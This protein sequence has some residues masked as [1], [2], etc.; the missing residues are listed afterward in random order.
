MRFRIY[1]LLGLLVCGATLSP[2]PSAQARNTLALLNA[3]QISPKSQIVDFRQTQFVFARG[4]SLDTDWGQVSVDVEN[5]KLRGMLGTSGGYLN[6]VLHDSRLGGPFW[7]VENLRIP[8]DSD[9][10]QDGLSSNTLREEQVDTSRKTPMSAYF[11]LRPG[12]E[13]SGSVNRLRAAVLVS[14][15]PLPPVL[16]IWNLLEQASPEEFRVSQQVNN[17]EG[18]LGE[19]AASTPPSTGP[20]LL[21]PPPQPIV[22]VPE[23][24]SDFAFP[25]EVIQYNQPN[26]NAAKNQ[27]VPMADALVIGY[28]RIRYNHPPL[29]WPLPHSSSAGLGLQITSADVISWEPEPESSRVAQLDARARRSGV[30]NF[31]TGGGTDRCNNIRAVFSYMATQGVPGQI[32]FRHQ[33]G[34]ATYGAG[35][36]CDNGD[37]LLPLG[38]ITSTR[39]GNNPT[40]QW[41][42]DQLQLGRGI[43]MSFG[44]YDVNGNR[45]SG[46]ALRIWG[47]R[48]FNGRNYIYTLDDGNQGS[49]NDG[50][51]NTQFEVAD[52]DTPGM[53]NVPNGRLE[54]GDTSSEIEFVMSME[55]KPTLLIP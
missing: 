41:I 42:F 19:V 9:C 10:R 37:V 55:A 48:R 47:A 17:A 53:P 24:P 35:N 44:R 36:S 2:W 7:V 38:G 54:L 11:D 20:L 50:L 49:N 12:I 28:L 18:D 33:G 21:G 6:V 40:W 30:L 5:V 52:N 1:S 27:C 4:S 8:P 23:L 39:Q 46:H 25:L 3:Q 15:G 22:P 26:I 51:Q 13:G 14:T 34:S 45:T 43:Y 31:D 16:S 32:V 29:A